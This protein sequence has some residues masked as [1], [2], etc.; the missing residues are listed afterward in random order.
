MRDTTAGLWIGPRVPDVVIPGRRCTQEGGI[1]VDVCKRGTVYVEPWLKN[2]LALQVRGP[3]L[4][5]PLS[6]T[7]F[8][9]RPFMSRNYPPGVWK[10]CL[11]LRESAQRGAAARRVGC[12]RPVGAQAAAFRGWP[13]R[14]LCGGRGA[15]TV[16][17]PPAEPAGEAGAVLLG[18]HAGLPQ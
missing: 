8:P 10:A 13:H 9:P 12:L 14:Q 3:H 16:P 18:D 7:T 15:A 11:V 5:F 2:A 17:L 1:C 4:P 6:R